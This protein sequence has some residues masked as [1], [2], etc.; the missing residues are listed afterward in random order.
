[1]RDS[2]NR[3]SQRRSTVCQRLSS[4]RLNFPRDRG[5]VE[6]RMPTHEVGRLSLMGDRK[7]AQLTAVEGRGIGHAGN[8]ALRGCR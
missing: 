1:M 6:L 8:P 2:G 5:E 4:I 7:L 3:R